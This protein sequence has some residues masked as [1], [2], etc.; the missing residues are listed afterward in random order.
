MQKQFGPY[1]IVAEI[2]RGGMGIVFRARESGS[3]RIVALKVL[4]TGNKGSIDQIQRFYRE[5]QAGSLLEHPNIVKIQHIGEQNGYP[6]FAMDYIEGYTLQRMINDKMP[7]RALITVV[8]KIARAL[9]AAHQA[10]IIHR[11]IK[12]SNILIAAASDEPYLSDF[13]LAK[14]LDQAT[15]TNS[16]ALLGTPFYM[17]PEQVNG[18]KA[19]HLS[20]IYALGVVLYQCL[21][22]RLPFAAETLPELYTQII[23]REPE[24][25]RQ[26]NA[27]V[28]QVLE[29]ICLT[30]MAKKPAERYQRVLDMA[31][32]LEGHL[33]RRRTVKRE[34]RKLVWKRALRQHR[35]IVIVAAVVLVV[36][37]GLLAGSIVSKAMPKEIP[38]KITWQIQ[39]PEEK[40]RI[41]QRAMSLSAAKEYEAAFSLLEEN[42]KKYG[43]DAA[44]YLCQGRIYAK[45]KNWPSAFS[46]LSKAIELEPRI[47]NYCERAQAILDAGYYEQ[48]QPDLDKAEGELNKIKISHRQEHP[49]QIKIIALRAR[50]A[51]CRHHFSQAYQLYQP[52]LKTRGVTAEAYFYGGLAAYHAGDHEQAIA[53][54]SQALG[55]ETLPN[56]MKVQALAYRGMA[57]RLE[58]QYDKAVSDLQLVS[59]QPHA[60]LGEAQANLADAYFRLGSQEQATKWLQLA[61]QNAP[62]L[63]LVSE[64]LSDYCYAEKNWH[65]AFQAIGKC[66]ALVPWESRYHYKAGL[67]LQS[68]KEYVQAEK[69]FKQA[70]ELK[71]G[72]VRPLVDL[73][74][75][76][77][78]Q[79]AME[80]IVCLGLVSI[81]YL[82]RFYLSA[83]VEDIFQDQIEVL[84]RQYRELSYQESKQQAT[85]S[86]SDYR[87]MLTLLLNPAPETVHQL[88]VESLA[89]LYASAEMNQAVAAQMK[90]LERDVKQR[91]TLERLQSLCKE[92]KGKQVKEQ[93]RGVKRTIVRLMAARDFSALVELDHMENAE[94]LLR[95]I[96]RDTHEDTVVRFLACQTLLEWGKFSTFRIVQEYL[97]AR[98][99]SES[100]LLCAVALKQKKFGVDENIFVQGLSCKNPFLRA[101]AV[102]HLDLQ[103]WS[104]L[105]PLLQD[106][107][108]KVAVYAAVRLLP[109]LP[110]CSRKILING[111]HSPNYLVRLYCLG[112]IWPFQNPFQQTAPAKLTAAMNESLPLIEQGLQDPHPLVRRLA[113]SRIA[114]HQLTSLS[115]DLY[116]LLQDKDILVQYQALN[117]IAFLG[118]DSKKVLHILYDENETLFLRS[119][120]V[121]TL[122]RTKDNI[123]LLARLRDASM[124]K[125]PRMSAL[126]LLFIGSMG[127]PM[128]LPPYLTHAEPCVRMAAAAGMVYSTDKE[129]LP[130]LQKLL[131]DLSPIVQKSAATSLTRVTLRCEP[132]KQPKL[133]E[134]LL[135]SAP[136]IK[137]G[138]ALGYYYPLLD[139]VLF[140]LMFAYGRLVTQNARVEDF[141]L[142]RH[143][144]FLNFVFEEYFLKEYREYSQ[145]SGQQ[146]HYL[147]LLSKAIELQPNAYY[148]YRRALLYEF[149][150]MWE[151]ALQDLQKALA[152]EPDSEWVLTSYA[153]ILAKKQEHEAVLQIC[154]RLLT[155]NPRSWVAWHLKAT[156]RH[157]Q[158]KREEA[159]NA[160][161]HACII[162]PDTAMLSAETIL[163][164]PELQSILGNNSGGGKAGEK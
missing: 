24:L 79:G 95:D 61:R 18:E 19:S 112:K 109:K 161:R 48:V 28:A 146:K 157:K 52:L 58:Q 76:M 68:D 101:L 103:K 122:L 106:E 116:P 145:N 135:Q 104:Y 51:L 56:D 121:P 35:R 55:A 99:D 9:Y 147:D 137:E 12:P 77:F 50:L 160:Y 107:E 26:L 17:S 131:K 63:P 32:E 154:E 43:P 59:D 78:D 25:P 155:V 82:L 125:D 65:E 11:D 142:A 153:N 119:A 47:E 100:A 111:C 113:A 118:T 140:K 1:E 34:S 97:E 158:G 117:T 44:V 90:E 102:R 96:L 8:A 31:Q 110:E 86:S 139:S 70:L 136:Q 75:C 81:A 38:K 41:V 2:A 124:Q 14:T 39:T 114:M 150:G 30:A 128:F 144:D 89:N 127:G 85:A 49:L 91:A 143:K 98:P 33:K 3:D 37:S 67:I 22:G 53:N 60:E 36:L 66:I 20:D 62:E 54:F 84:S 69:F 5:A 83:D 141:Q 126:L 6:Y 42:L 46:C 45:Q 87:K 15:L 149:G 13:G 156:I 115:K 129:Q 27:H 57:Y 21:T 132:E 93:K 7:L 130:K 108:E 120:V 134:M 71:P 40:S 148:Y 159:L 152:M 80:E 64:T 162:A 163:Q 73:L 88:A 133:H 23:G 138:A 123:A 105:E 4:L 72:D 92:I 94:P 151:K 10:K 29:N 74:S 16:G 164:F